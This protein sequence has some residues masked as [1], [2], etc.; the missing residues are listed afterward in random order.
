MPRHVLCYFGKG[1]SVA[2]EAN[3]RKNVCA[4]WLHVLADDVEA[5]ALPIAQFSSN[6]VHI[7]GIADTKARLIRETDSEVQ[8]AVIN[9]V[10]K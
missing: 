8:R 2:R 7:A 6:R 5:S 9:G 4:A 3:S 1:D 10:G